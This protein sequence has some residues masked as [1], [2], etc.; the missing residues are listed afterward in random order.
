MAPICVFRGKLDTDSDP[1]Q[2]PALRTMA[3]AIR[4]KAVKLNRLAHC[5]AAPEQQILAHI[6][7]SAEQPPIAP[8][9][10]PL[11]WYDDLEPTRDWDLIAQPDPDFALDQ[12]NYR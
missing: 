5:E 1:K 3:T 8:A 9:L 4:P 10:G 11:A 6:G 12:R 7:A 2:P